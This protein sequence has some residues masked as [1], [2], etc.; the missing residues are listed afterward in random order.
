VQ[1]ADSVYWITMPLPFGLDHINLWLLRDEGSWVIVDTGLATEDT[2]RQWEPLLAECGKDGPVHRV[3][4]THFHPDHLSLAGWL[5]ERLDAELCI[6]QGEYLSALAFG[7]GAAGLGGPRTAAL[8]ERHGLVGPTL[9]KVAARSDAFRVYYAGVPAGY[10]R[11]MD[12]DVLSIN[13]RSW[14]VM[15]GYGHS[16]EHAALHCEELGV[17]I[18]GDMVLP[19][20]SPNVSAPS[21]EPDGDPLSRYLASLQ[22]YRELPE[23]TVVAPSHGLVFRGLHARIDALKSHHED[24]CATILQAC[25]S[26]PKTACELLPLLYRRELGSSGTYFAMGETIAHLN[27]LTDRG[28]LLRNQDEEGMYRF[29]ARR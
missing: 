17:F 29:T 28:E 12:N 16:P 24:C 13:G 9:E 2:R 6:S 26:A 20:I 7:T 15:M 8:F 19:G 23:D 5:T 27:H 21:L 1:V 18:S 3:V 4:A 11:L 14:Q 10:R 25:R 22:R